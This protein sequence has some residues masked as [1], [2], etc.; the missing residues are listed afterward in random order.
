MGDTYRMEVVAGQP[1]A[2]TMTF[3]GQGI[4]DLIAATGGDVE[5]RAQVRSGSSERYALVFDLTPFLSTSVD[6]IAGE[7]VVTVSMTGAETRTAKPGYYDMFI[8]DPGAADVRGRKV[9]ETS[10]F[11]VEA[12]VTSA[13]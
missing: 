13:S 1:Y 10:R 8:T 9:L 2:C 11:E 6:D 4:V 3:T 12:A 5:V 7:I